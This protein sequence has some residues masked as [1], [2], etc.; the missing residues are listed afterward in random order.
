MF[1]KNC[2]KF[3]IGIVITELYNTRN[4]E[5]KIGRILFKIVSFQLSTRVLYSIVQYERDSRNADFLT[6]APG[7][8]SL[9][10]SHTGYFNI[11]TLFLVAIG[12]EAGDRK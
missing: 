12:Q 6:S 8:R 7:A 3:L 11:G 2:V 10:D 5:C 1:L 4:G 9:S